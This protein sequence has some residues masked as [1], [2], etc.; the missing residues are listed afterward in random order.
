M[1]RSPFVQ[2]R[3][4]RLHLVDVH[5][6]AFETLQSQTVFPG[7]ALPR[8]ATESELQ[9]A[10][11]AIAQSADDGYF[12][13]VKAE[14]NAG[15]Q[16]RVFSDMVREGGFIAGSK[17]VLEP[18]QVGISKVMQY[19]VGWNFTDSEDKPVPVS[20]SA[21]NNLHPSIFTDIMSAIDWHEDEVEKARAAR[22]NDQGTEKRSSETSPSLVGATGAS[23]G[24]ES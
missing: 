9:A 3:V 16:R 12:I 15:E 21:V 13:D 19:L 6:R 4:V 2:P 10:R 24:S 14:L 18:Q 7:T 11:D 23:S 5:R 1:G 17:P 22:K 20:E 8:K